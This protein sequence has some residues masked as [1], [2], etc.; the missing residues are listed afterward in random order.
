MIRSIPI[1]ISGPWRRIRAM[2]TAPA[3]VSLVHKQ[4]RRGRHAHGFTRR[5]L[6]W[7]RVLRQRFVQPA[8]A[9]LR[10]LSQEKLQHRFQSH[11]AFPMEHRTPRAWRIS[12]CSPIG[13]TNRRCATCWLTKSCASAGVAAHFAFTVRVQ[14]NGSFFSTAD[15]VEDA[16]E[17]YLERAG[18][19]KDGALYKV[20]ANLLNK[21]AGNTATSGVEKKTRRFENNSDLQ[22]LINGL[23]LTGP[24]LVELSLRQHRYSALRQHARGQLG[25]PEHRYA[26]QELVYLSRYR[27]ERRVGHAPVGPGPIARPRLEHTKYLFRQRALHGWFRR[28]RHCHPAGLAALRQSGHARHDPATHPD[29]DR[30]VPSAPARAWNARKRNSITSGGSTSNRR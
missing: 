12:I 16:D 22:A 19:N 28:Q 26:Q 17:I 3:G 25:H 10:R 9:V 18:L 14:Q 5:G 1:N 13:R 23:D 20:Y 2:Q 6:L 7:G 11:P 8:R 21:D 24:A 29:L 30:S 15:F 27:P 4:R